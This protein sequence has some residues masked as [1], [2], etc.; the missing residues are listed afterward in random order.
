MA[1]YTDQ[2][3]MITPVYSDIYKTQQ[4]TKNTGSCSFNAIQ[5]VS[6]GV[7][8]SNTMIVIIMAITPSLNASSL[9]LFISLS[10]VRIRTKRRISP[11]TYP[12]GNEKT[13]AK[14]N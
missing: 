5:L 4:I 2:M 10:G 9:F 1:Q 11:G 12:E 6:W 8:I 7:L 13:Y 14:K 3:V